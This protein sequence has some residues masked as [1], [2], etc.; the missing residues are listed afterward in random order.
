MHPPTLRIFQRPLTADRS[1]NGADFSLS[2]RQCRSFGQ[3]SKEAGGSSR[4]SRPPQV[5]DFAVFNRD[6]WPKVLSHSKGIPPALAFREIIGV[7]KGLANRHHPTPP[8]FRPLSRKE[9]QEMEDKISLAVIDR[10]RLYD[11]YE[12]Y[13]KLRRGFGDVD[14]VDRVISVLDAISGNV[15]LRG[16]IEQALDEVYVDGRSCSCA[17]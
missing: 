17:H 3:T 14:G 13:E 12:L 6:Y 7:I 10:E 15:D 1:T 4:L 5:V 16:K 8:N 9:Y 2:R 11:L